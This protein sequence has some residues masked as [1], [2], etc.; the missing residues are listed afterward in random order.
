MEPV[1]PTVRRAW[2]KPGSSHLLASCVSLSKIHALSEPCFLTCG[3]GKQF[4]LRGGW[5][6]AVYIHNA[7]HQAWHIVS[8]RGCG[9]HKPKESEGWGGGVEKEWILMKRDM[10]GSWLAVS[11]SPI[12][13]LKGQRGDPQDWSARALSLKSSLPSLCSVSTSPSFPPSLPPQVFSHLARTG[14]ETNFL[15]SARTGKH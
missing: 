5:I 8:G 1:D 4:L 13:F 15:P 11:L 2:F 9:S 3:E 7:W 6:S 12:Q 14:L 10:H